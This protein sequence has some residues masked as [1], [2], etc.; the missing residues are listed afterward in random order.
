MSRLGM[1]MRRSLALLLL[2]LA[3]PSGGAIAQSTLKDQ[4]VGTWT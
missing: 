4:I 1:R 2:A 3:L